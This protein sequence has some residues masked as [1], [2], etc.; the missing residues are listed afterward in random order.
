MTKTLMEH[1]ESQ[2][3]FACPRCGAKS[4]NPND[5]RERYC[6]RCHVFDETRQR[7][8]DA[9]LRQRRRI[10]EG[11]SRPHRPSDSDPAPF[12]PFTPYEPP[13]ASYEPPAPPTALPDPPSTIDPG[14]GSSGG[15][16]ASGDF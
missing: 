9:K 12:A 14:G 10:E 3:H 7:F 11:H 1:W 4:W 15:G 8:Q 13:A 5:I 16:G 2:P 6:G